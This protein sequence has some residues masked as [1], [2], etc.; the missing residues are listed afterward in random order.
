[1]ICAILKIRSLK[2]I[3]QEEFFA[4]EILRGDPENLD[5]GQPLSM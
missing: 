3:E 1:V 4:L 5:G 2:K